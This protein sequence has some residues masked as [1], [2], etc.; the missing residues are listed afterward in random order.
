LPKGEAKGT[1]ISL[2]LTPEE[3]ALFQA[4]ADKEGLSLSAFIRKAL[5]SLSQG[6]N[7]LL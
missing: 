6:I 2:R 1:L 4:S 5:K 3:R 7:I